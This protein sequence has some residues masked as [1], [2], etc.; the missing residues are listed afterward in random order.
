MR[1]INRDPHALKLQSSQER[2]SNSSNNTF[3]SGACEQLLPRAAPAE[4]QISE[5]L[6]KAG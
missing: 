5:Q 4:L 6:S 2:Q 3:Q 1:N